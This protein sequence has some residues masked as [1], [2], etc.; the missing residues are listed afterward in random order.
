M[1]FREKIATLQGQIDTLQRAVNSLDTIINAPEPVFDMGYKPTSAAAREMLEEALDR[2]AKETGELVAENLPAV[3]RPRKPGT[4]T[5]LKP[6]ETIYD[7]AKRAT[8][9]ADE[10][11]AAK[12]LWRNQEAMCRAA[13]LGAEEALGEPRGEWP[14][15]EG[16]WLNYCEWEYAEHGNVPSG[17]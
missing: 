1:I 17:T 16:G 15:D 11:K 6:G 13:M 4:I 7:A 2:A 8:L 9:P 12:D 5:R 14:R 10:I 3:F